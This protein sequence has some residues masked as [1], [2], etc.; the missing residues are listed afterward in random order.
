M[1][2][3]R[4]NQNAYF[5]HAVTASYRCSLLQR[6]P[7]PLAGRLLSGGDWDDVKESAENKPVLTGRQSLLKFLVRV[8]CATELLSI[9]KENKDALEQHINPA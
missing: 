1:T 2:L 8:I 3:V 6:V 4:I 5:P 9:V 7:V